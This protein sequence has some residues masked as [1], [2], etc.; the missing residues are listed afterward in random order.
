MNQGR[1]IYIIKRRLKHS[2]K[3][4]Q[5]STCKTALTFL[6]SLY[7]QKNTIFRLPYLAK[8]IKDTTSAP[9]LILN[10]LRLEEKWKEVCRVL[11]YFLIK[12]NIKKNRVRLVITKDLR[13]Y[14][15]FPPYHF[16]D[17]YYFLPSN[18]KIMFN[19]N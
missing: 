9:I 2:G 16:L 15:E 7:S 5:G 8:A 18:T 6:C 3:S 11:K 10:M 13:R 12:K 17:R 19:I 4:G 14:R 1:V